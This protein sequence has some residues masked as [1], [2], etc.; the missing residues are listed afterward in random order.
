MSEIFKKCNTI[1]C[2]KIETA[3]WIYENELKDYSRYITENK[4]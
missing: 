3:P 2:M 4:Y 1:S